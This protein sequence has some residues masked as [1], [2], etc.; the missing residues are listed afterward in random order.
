MAEVVFVPLLRVGGATYRR[1]TMPIDGVRG[2]RHHQQHHQQH[3]ADAGGGADDDAEGEAAW[4][5]QQQQQQRQQQADAGDGSGV[6]L[7]RDGDEWVTRVL[8]DPELLPLIIGKERHRAREIEASTG[9]ALSFPRPPAGARGGQG[10]P[11]Q[12]PQQPAAAAAAA[13]VVGAARSEAITIRAP[14]RAAAASA[15]ARVEQAITAAISSRFVDFT[16]FV[17]LPLAN[18]AATDERLT[19]FRDQVLAAPG[20]A[21]AGLEASVF[22]DAAKLH[23]T[24]VMLKL[25][26]DAARHA[27]AEALRGLAPAAREL[28]GGEPLRV[29]LA[30]LEVMRGD[31][32]DAHVLY[33]KVAPEPAGDGRL[34]RLCELVVAAFKAAGLL[35]PGQ[36]E[37]VKLHATVINTRHRHVP[38]GGRERRERVG[39]DARALLSEWG[40]LDLGELTLASLELSTRGASDARGYYAAAATLPLLDG[41]GARSGHT[42]DPMA[43]KS[44][45][46]GGVG[47]APGVDDVARIA[48]GGQPVA[49]DAAGAERI[50]RESPPPKA[51]EPEPESPAPAGGGPALSAQQARAV[52][53]TRL[54]SLMAG[55][56]GVRLAVADFLAA[57]LNAGLPPALPAADDASALGALADAC[58][59]LGGLAA[60][61][62]RPLAAAAAAAGLSPPGLSAA[63]RA[64]IS[65]GASAS[66]GVASLVIVG[67]RQLLGAVT[68]V[69]ALACEAAGAQTKAFDAELVEARGYKGAVAAADELRSLLDGSRAA[70]G[71]KGL[72]LDAQA[73]FSSLPQALGAAADAVTVAYNNVRPEVQS[74]ALPAKAG[75]SGAAPSPTLAPALVD[76]ARALLA[77]A[78]SCVSR[79]HV[80]A[81]ACPSAAAALQQQ[82]AAVADGMLAAAQQQLAAVGGELLGPAGVQWRAGG[83]GPELRAALAAA[84]ALDALQTAAALEGLAA[85]A[86]LRLAEGPAPEPAPAADAAAGEQQQQQDGQQKG[87]GDKK[88]DKKAQGLGLGRGT[89]VVRAHLERAVAAAAAAG[90]AVGP[91]GTL[92]VLD[93]QLGGADAVLG[94]AAGLDAAAGVLSAHEAA[95]V[96]LA[97]DL[98][99]VVEANQATRKPKVAKGARDF[100]PDQMAIREAAFNTITGVFK[101]HGAVSIDTPVFELRE[102][103]MG[104][105]GE[106]SKLIYDLADQGGELL[107]LRYDLTVP[108]ARY[109][110][111]NGVGNIKRYHIGKVYRRDQPQ[112]ARGRFREFFQCDFDIAGSYAAMV[113][114]AE[115]LAVVVEILTSLRLGPFTVKLNHRRLLDAMLAIAGVPPQKFRPICSAIDKL[116]KEPWPVVRA[117]MVEEKGLPGDVADAIG[118]FVVLKGA[119]RELLA[120][121]TAPGHPLAAHPDSAAALSELRSLF[122]FLDALGALGPISFDL[123]L[124]RGLDYYTGVIYEAVLDGGNVGS[125]AAGGR[126]DKLVGMFSGKDVPAVGVSI[127][128][129]RVFTIMEAQERARAAESGAAIRATATQ[130]LVASI[131]NGMQAKRM[132]VASRL[133]AAGIAAEF[134]FKPNPKM[135][136][137]LGYALEQGIP[138]LVLFGEDELAAGQARRGARAARAAL[139]ARR[140]GVVRPPRGGRRRGRRRARGAQVKV[141]HMAAKTEETVPLEGLVDEL[142]RLLAEAMLRA[143]VVTLWML[144][145]A[146]ALLAGPCT[147]ARRGEQPGDRQLSGAEEQLPP[148]PPLPPLEL[149]SSELVADAP[150]AAPVRRLLAAGPALAAS[151][152]GKLGQQIAPP[153]SLPDG[154]LFGVSLAASADGAVAV[155]GAPLGGAAAAPGRALV[156]RRGSA[157][158]CDYVPAPLAPPADGSASRDFG[159]QAAL[160]AN[161]ATLLVLGG[162]EAAPGAGAAAGERPVTHVYRRA[163]G[164]GGYAHLQRLPC[165][166]RAAPVGALAASVSARGEVLVVSFA[167]G[168]DGSTDRR[169]SAQVFVQNGTRGYV[170]LQDLAELSMPAGPSR[171]FGAASAIS[172]DGGV[173]A[174][175][176]ASA[177]D[178]AVKH[179]YLYLRDAATGRFK[180][181]FSLRHAPLASAA[182]TLGRGASPTDGGG[183]LALS[184]AGRFLLRS[185]GPALAVF[186]SARAGAAATWLRRCTLAAPPG[187]D[188]RAG[189]YALSAVEASGSRAKFA[190]GAV[191]ADHGAGAAVLWHLDTSKPGSCPWRPAEVHMLSG[192]PLA[193]F[194]AAVALSGDGKLLLVGAPT[195]PDGGAAGRRA[196]A[197]YAYD[198]TA[199]ADDGLVAPADASAAAAASADPG[200]VG[201]LDASGNPC[202]VVV[203]VGA[204]PI[205]ATGGVVGSA[206]S[207]PG[208]ATTSALSASTVLASRS[209]GFVSLGAN[210]WATPSTGVTG[211]AT[212]VFFGAS[213]AGARSGAAGSA[214]SGGSG[215]GALGGGGGAASAAAGGT[216]G[217]T[218]GG[219]SALGTIGTLLSGMGQHA[220]GRATAAMASGPVLA[221]VKDIA[222]KRVTA[223]AARLKAKERPNQRYV[224]PAR[225]G[226]AYALLHRAAE[227]GSPEIVLLLLRAGADANA[228]DSRGRTPLHWLAA[229]AG[230]AHAKVVEALLKAKGVDLQALSDKKETPAHE[231]AAAGNARLLGQ[232][233]A[234][235]ADAGDASPGHTLLHAACQ[236]APD[237]AAAGPVINALL[238]AAPGV[239]AQHDAA[240]WTPLMRLLG[241]GWAGAARELLARGDCGVN[242]RAAGGESA[243][244]LACGAAAPDAQLVEALLAAG[245][246]RGAQGGAGGDTP[247]LLAVKR[248]GAAGLALARQLLGPGGDSSGSGS[249]GGGSCGDACGINAAD[250]AG[251]TAVALAGAAA[252]APSAGEPALQLLGL[253]L[254]HQAALPAEL[255]ADLLRRG[256]AR[257]LPDGV[258][259]QLLAALP[260][261][262]VAAAAAAAAGLAQPLS[263]EGL[264][265]AGLPRTAVAHLLRASGGAPGDPQD[266][267]GNTHL[268]SAVAGPDDA[269]ELVAA[270]LA[271]G[272]PPDA[273]N[274]DGDTPLHVAARRGHAA[275]CAALVAGG[276][277]VLRRNQKNRS[278]GG[279]LKL[280]EATRALLAEAEAAARAARAERDRGTW[281][282]GI[283]AAQTASAVCMRVAERGTAPRA[284]A[285]RRPELRSAPRAM[286]KA[287]M[288]LLEWSQAAAAAANG[289]VCALAGPMACSRK[290]PVG[291][292]FHYKVLLQAGVIELPGESSSSGSSDDDGGDSTD[293]SSARGMPGSSSVGS[294]LD[295][296]Q[297]PPGVSWKKSKA[298]KKQ[299]KAK[300]EVDYYALLGLQHE[301][302]MATEAQLKQAYRKACLEHHPDKKLVG[303]DCEVAKGEAEE[304]FKAIQAAYDTLSDPAKRREYDSVDEFDDSLP[305]DCDPADFFKVFGPAFRRN[306]RWSSEP[307]VPEVGDEST[308]WE[309]VSAFYDFWYAFRSWRE[310][311]HPDEEDVEGAESREHRRW[312]ERINSKLREKG[313]KEEGRRLRE[314]V[315]AAYRVDPRVAA[316]REA[317]AAERE[318]KKNEK[319]EARRAAAEAELRKKEEEEAARAAEEA[320]AKAAA[321]E[322]KKAREVEKRAVKKERQRLRSLAAP[323]GVERLLGVDDTERLCASLDLSA[324]QALG[325]AASAEGVD[326]AAR[327]ALL[328]AA[329][330]GLDAREEDEARA[331]EAKKRE[332]EAALKTMA[333]R[334]HARKVEAMREWDDDELR[335]LDKAVKKFPTGTPRR[336]EQVAAYVRTR[337]LEEVLLMVKERQGASSTR[338]R[339]QEDWKGAAKKRAEVTSEADT[340]DAAFTDV[341][342]KVAAEAAE[343]L[344]SSGGRAAPAD[345][346]SSTATA[347]G[348]AGG[349]DGADA[350]P[351]KV[352]A[353]DSGEWGEE[354]DRALV[355]ALKQF[356][357]E[358][359]DRWER[360]AGVVPGKGKAACFKRFKELRDAQQQPEQQPEQIDIAAAKAAGDAAFKAGQ[361]AEAE[362]HYSDALVA[363][364]AAADATHLRAIYSNRAAARLALADWRGALADAQASVAVDDGWAKGWFRS[365]RALQQ[366]GRPALAAAAAARAVALAPGDRG[367][368]ELLAALR[369][370]E[371]EQQSQSPSQSQQQPGPPDDPAPLLPWAQLCRL[372]AR[373]PL[374]LLPPP[375]VAGSCYLPSPDGVNANLLLLLHGLGDTPAAFTALARR[376][377]LPQTA[378]LAL[379]GPLRVPETHGGR[380]WFESFEADGELIQPRPGDTRRLHSLAATVSLVRQQLLPALSAAGGWAPEQLQLL[381]F[382]QGGTVALELARACRGAACRLG[383]V[384]AVSAALLEEALDQ[385]GSG[386]GGDDAGGGGGGCDALITHG[387][388]DAVVPRPLVSRSVA[389]LAAA[390]CAARLVPVPGKGHGMIGGEAEIR[391][392]MEFWGARLRARPVAADASFVEPLRLLAA[393]QALSGGWQ[394]AAA[395]AAAAHAQLGSA[396]AAPGG[397]ADVCWSGDDDRG[398]GSVPPARQRERRHQQ[399]QQQRIAWPPRPGPC[400][401]PRGGGHPL[402]WHLHHLVAARGLATTGAGAAGA[403]AAGT[404]A[405]AATGWVQR[406]LPAAAQPYAQ[407]MRLDKPIGS[408]LLAWPGLWSIALAAPPGHLPD[409]WLT[410]LFGVG[411]VVRRAPGRAT[412]VMRGAGCTINDLWDRDIDA[413]VARTAGRPLASGALS[414]A[415]ALAALGAQLG[416]GL[417]VLLQLNGTTQAL[418]VASLGL[419]VAYPLMKR[420][421]HWPQAFLGLTMN[422]GAIMGYAA[423]AGTPDWAVVAPLY[424]AG[425]CWTLVYDTIYAHQDK[426]DDVAVGVKST[427]L[428]FG[429]R[430]K[431]W[432]AGFATA[433]AAALTAAG[434]AAGCGPALFAAVAAGAAHQAWQVWTVDL[435]DGP[436]CNAKFVSN[437]WYGAI[438][439]AGL[440]ADRLLAAGGA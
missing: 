98:R 371:R 213:G 212:S 216:A 280:P 222:A 192:D 25:C 329:V 10:P 287:R 318:R 136:D 384:V 351:K 75:V 435:D 35:Q 284:R 199:A 145:A 278:P 410:A 179:T 150:A 389:A 328:A 154:S 144:V 394:P 252:S 319:A 200:C 294:N 207:T 146:G 84:A 321:A 341:E 66:A 420:F 440:V 30:G 90:A 323:E 349:G 163:T 41:L 391:A 395:A 78:H 28:L 91:S 38:G 33:L 102:T 271:A 43:A 188:L 97:D 93:G 107:S 419:V 55:K 57:L 296:L 277:D 333:A 297:P 174:V 352:V 170:L 20:A 186:E 340:R 439:Y 331:R 387:D 376:M 303:I 180:T 322:A 157:A 415:A 412:P 105:Y 380:A 398:P 67:T 134:G 178:P 379:S 58:K 310:F 397:Q 378:C 242:A 31:P 377:A 434:A 300:E 339:A 42:A 69:A 176:A 422:Y 32:S 327:A 288:L 367:A 151:G 74:A 142:R 257:Q 417:C 211:L 302:W 230:D 293:A 266:G 363:S 438:I 356:G 34:A 366:L 159:A 406:W 253:L 44:F 304:H 411:A 274:A 8:V 399:A 372:R 152:C 17:S 247:L 355:A 215:T 89:A 138:F 334:D 195:A 361:H 269:P 13:Q 272:A 85:V 285:G 158:A 47:A 2:T 50:K 83:P 156:L 88:K 432:A 402:P 219:R 421:T 428:L 400:C 183:A 286:A 324:L 354:Q 218:T 109:V 316:R 385:P 127:G 246:A 173:I 369:A 320:A 203:V 56:S 251:G 122:D 256:L 81:G 141:K 27:A 292:G 350:P 169:G 337:T 429:D 382:S 425:V 116:D 77:L 115:V 238:A 65:A 166:P 263:F 73:P 368:L 204:R 125:I 7:E 22:A 243:L 15:R 336:W 250:A 164:G 270:L 167:I 362:E 326:P 436:D 147:A 123:S 403:G 223:V 221:F 305:L 53:A 59:G 275:A 46:V 225:Q 149:A 347:A 197:V 273:A 237:W 279:Q 5:A 182:S 431:A 229:H 60:D 423:A 61:P 295:D 241:C 249:C 177:T 401:A 224:D 404:G 309:E 240:G 205:T 49:L 408:W 100:M 268:H 29:R 191:A 232:L 101:R 306:A 40:G 437:A 130:V 233:L 254:A 267:A 315:D 160:S 51:F 128:I 120:A 16:H 108:F 258:T 335:M 433:Q 234:A 426:A 381:G 196:G 72:P 386:G 94:S 208:G 325:D 126:Y 113:P 45:T 95:A 244:L 23:L 217:S 112:L 312:I 231:A 346:S 314:F 26:S 407:L 190:A 260:G 135:G 172:A 307:A 276:A 19:E 413:R 357:K 358:L 62:A 111:V 194:G 162:A 409:P 264:V 140:A 343:R 317:Q 36:A 92:Q 290:E 4:E 291:H 416:A 265:H 373:M 153:P 117:E 360:I 124:A 155:A 143:L 79:V 80:L 202:V 338:T 248:G 114:D 359:P 110:A 189:G 392:V 330:A 418:G 370:Q 390:G 405:P 99:A 1:R 39:V 121:L 37:H 24:L 165:A 106:D 239:L 18:G 206:I 259:A 299:A 201:G 3:S 235:G 52:L 86:V 365:A 289:M 48:L 171:E 374:A 311:P 54:M 139:L 262:A 332:A 168:G 63:E 313:K 119:P 6:P 220:A 9:A 261:D 364:E 283:A 137:Q 21:E 132:A 82:A 383:G 64:A 375:L 103:L 193:S 96:Q 430:T 348:A 148:L 255:G 210:A 181:V 427:A 282:A 214:L 424:A 301:R 414:P 161:G 175:A 353:A 209:G 342:V 308:P 281:G 388:A 344:A 68:A 76:A 185:E 396:L 87:K 198:V 184:Q 236:G 227:A 11:R 71:R 70:G 187:F 131:G 245:A 133:W 226:L 104:K 345:S 393:C 129:E 12:R 118:Q 14:S 228:R 298:K